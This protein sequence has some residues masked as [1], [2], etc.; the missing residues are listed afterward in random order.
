MTKFR[1]LLLSLIIIFVCALSL[2]L[3]IN[4]EEKAEEYKINVNAETGRAGSS[5]NMTLDGIDKEE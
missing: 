4:A 2:I 3:N 1:K 5:L